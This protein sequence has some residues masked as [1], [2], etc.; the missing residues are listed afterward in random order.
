MSAREIT[1]DDID[2][3]AVG[4]RILGTDDSSTPYLRLLNMR[5]LY[6][7]GHRAGGRDAAAGAG[8]SFRSRSVKC[9]GGAR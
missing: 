6:V 1:R 4:A 3:L 9:G 8:T 7:E 2:A 5:P